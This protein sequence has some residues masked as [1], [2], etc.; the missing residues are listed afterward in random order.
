MNPKVLIIVSGGVACVYAD[1]GVGVVIADFDDLK[2]TDPNA[3]T[4]IHSSFQPLMELA[5]IVGD[6]P[7]SEHDAVLDEAR[8]PEVV[9]GTYERE[10]RM[11]DRDSST[12]HYVGDSGF[13]RG[14]EE[15]SQVDQRRSDQ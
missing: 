13:C 14:S 2:A 4:P 15:D 7:L 5:G 11:F 1:P 9:R 6:W 8:H 10:V 3:I 12:G